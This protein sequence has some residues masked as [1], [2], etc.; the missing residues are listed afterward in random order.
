MV[1]AG[2]NDVVRASKRYPWDVLTAFALV[3]GVGTLTAGVPL[4]FVERAAPLTAAGAALEVIVA[5]RLLAGERVETR[6]AAAAAI[7]GGA[8]ALVVALADLLN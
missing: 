6:A 8:I 2:R 4:A 3:A 1:E 7:L 5:A